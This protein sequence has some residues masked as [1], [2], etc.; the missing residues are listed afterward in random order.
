L[1]R[2]MCKF[3]SSQKDESRWQSTD[4]SKAYRNTSAFRCSWAAMNV[5]VRCCATKNYVEQLLF[6]CP[7]AE[8]T[9]RKER[10]RNVDFFNKKHQLSHSLRVCLCWWCFSH[11]K[12]Q[13]GFM[14]LWKKKAKIFR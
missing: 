11:D 4:S 14:N 13:T 9:T 6:C 10:F 3:E 8:H 2:D 1:N 12:N 5:F 7:L